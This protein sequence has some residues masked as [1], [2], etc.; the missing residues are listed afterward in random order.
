MYLQLHLSWKHAHGYFAPS[1][2]LR[3]CNCSLLFLNRQL[4]VKTNYNFLS[5]KIPLKHIESIFIS[6]LISRNYKW[7]ISRRHT[8]RR[9][10]VIGLSRGLRYSRSLWLSRALKLS[11]G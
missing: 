7:K 1:F 9:R 6:T 2:K 10:R 8:S 5:M 3:Q 4:L 11:R